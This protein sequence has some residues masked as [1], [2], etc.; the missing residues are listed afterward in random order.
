VSWCIETTDQWKRDLGRYE[1]KHPDE[2]S[3]ILQNLDK[4]HAA[5]CASK[6]PRLVQ[7]GFLHK[8]PKG[9]FAIDQTGGALADGRKRGKLQETRLYT[10]AVLESNTLHLLTIGSKNTQQKD[11][12]FA[13]RAVTA[14]RDRSTES[15]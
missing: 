8:E 5:I 4:Y 10:Y 15:T 3:A 1:K 12:A 11:I 13:E 2:L 7:F 9:I 14:I 6:H